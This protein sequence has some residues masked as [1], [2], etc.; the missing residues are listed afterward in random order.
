MNQREG[1]IFADKAA[2]ASYTVKSNVDKGGMFYRELWRGL[3]TGRESFDKQ[4]GQLRTRKTNCRLYIHKKNRTYG[5]AETTS[6]EEATRG[7]ASLRRPIVSDAFTAVMMHRAA[8][9]VLSLK[10]YEAS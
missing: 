4:S 2:E 3:H 9:P 1:G 7:K 10:L 8:G 5:D 6:K